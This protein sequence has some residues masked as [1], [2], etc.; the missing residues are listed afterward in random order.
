M[1]LPSRTVM[2]TLF[3]FSILACFSNLWATMDSVVPVSKAA[4]ETLITHI[5]GETKT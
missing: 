4:L 2:A 3:V 5:N 1:V